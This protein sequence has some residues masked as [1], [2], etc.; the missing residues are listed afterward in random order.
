MKWYYKLAPRWLDRIIF[1][2]IYRIEIR[3]M[4]EMGSI[5]RINGRIT[6]IPEKT[7]QVPV[8]I[9]PGKYWWEFW[10]RI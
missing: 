10:K 3:E 4:L 8:Q 1:H 9:G 2:K 6:F 7:K 5:K